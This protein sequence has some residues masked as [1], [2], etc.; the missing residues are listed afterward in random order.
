MHRTQGQHDNPAAAGIDPA[1]GTASAGRC[2]LPRMDGIIPKGER[3]VI[4]KPWNG[5]AEARFEAA[6]AAGS[7][8]KPAG[9]GPPA[10]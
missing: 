6:D 1:I 5:P 2:G 10:A 3:A 9:A 7:E 4:V 8:E